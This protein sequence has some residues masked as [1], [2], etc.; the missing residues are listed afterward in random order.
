MLILVAQITTAARGN[1]CS[2][3]GI[4]TRIPILDNSFGHSPWKINSPF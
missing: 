4:G 3:M 1:L 2:C